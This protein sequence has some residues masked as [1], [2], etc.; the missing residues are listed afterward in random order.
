VDL[1]KIAWV[2]L[3]T[4]AAIMGVTYFLHEHLTDTPT[5]AQAAAQET[6]APQ[7]EPTAEPEPTGTDETDAAGR[8]D[9]ADPTGDTADNSPRGDD[10]APAYEHTM[11]ARSTKRYIGSANPASDFLFQLETVNRGASIYTL[12]LSRH[13]STIEDKEFAAEH[14]EDYDQLWPEQEGLRGPYSLLNPIDAGKKSYLPFA[15]RAIWWSS[16][17]LGRAWITTLDRLNWQA[18]EPVISDSEQSQSY[19]F[20]VWHKG[21]KVFTLVKT[22]TVK[23]GE[24]SF[25][26]DLSIENH[27]PEPVR[28]CIDQLGPAGVPKEHYKPGEDLRQMVFGRYNSEA[29]E[30]VV[31]LL[32][33]QGEGREISLNA[34]EK[35]ANSDSA[36]PGLWVA[37][38][39][40]YF[41]SSLYVVP[42]DV[43]TQQLN[44]PKARAR[45]YYGATM[46]N[47]ISRNFYTGVMFGRGQ[48]DEINPQISIKPGETRSIELNVFSGPKKRSMFNDEQEYPLYAR[49]NYMGLIDVSS[50]CPCAFSQLAFV[51]MWLLETFSVVMLG[52]Y[53]LAIMLLVVVVR[54]ILHPLSRKSQSSMAKM[55]KLKP[56]MEKIQE[57]YKDD[58][59]TQQKEVMKL[60]RQQGASPFLGC[61]PMFLQIPIWVAL[62]TSVNVSVELRHAG[63]LPIWLTDLSTPDSLISWSQPLL[64]YLSSF[65]LLP[66]LL[67]L[68]M[69]FQMKFSPQMAGQAAAATPEQQAQQKMFRYLMPG[70]MLVIFYNQPSGLTLYIMAS[71]FVGV[72]ESKIIRQHIE[73]KEAREAASEVVVQGPGKAARGARPKK[74]KGPFW[75]KQG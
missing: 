10:D 28:I 43:E 67:G 42:D 57:K 51:M 69:Y 46:E 60:Y 32:E 37:A 62:W 6:D 64:G 58:K 17:S 20:H 40:K 13:Q 54:L 16:P 45:F 24:E 15:T 36:D 1:R 47:K 12:K 22:Y 3:F 41:A 21:V 59:A 34:D 63:L 39:N 19:A 55:Q 68:A 25:Y 18:R 26:V 23:A 50:G 33:M 65:N 48:S 70:M 5:K 52:N 35:L 29:G 31:K 72:L 56:E 38:T 2:M 44:A 30:V 74:P 11:F 73:N 53:G 9:P 27:Y 61:L 66:L 75:H 71:T 7:D 4:G 8:P 49:L 14:P